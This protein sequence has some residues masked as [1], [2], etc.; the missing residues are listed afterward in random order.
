[1][2]INVGDVLSLRS[3]PFPVDAKIFTE[4]EVWFVD[5]VTLKKVSRGTLR[6]INKSL[7][8]LKRAW[9]GVTYRLL[10]ANPDRMQAWYQRVEEHDA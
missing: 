2:P 9:D 5:A 8:P 7:P 6:T 3:D 10:M 1:M 4:W